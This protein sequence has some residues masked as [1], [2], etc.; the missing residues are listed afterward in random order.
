MIIRYASDLHLDFSIPEVNDVL[1]PALPDDSNSVLV[2][3]G[4]VANGFRGNDYIKRLSKRF[5][6]IIYVLGNHEYYGKDI[7]TIKRKLKKSF[8]EYK[9]VHILE[10]DFVVI[11]IDGDLA[12][13]FGCTLWT[14]FAHDFA[15]MEK[16][17]L[18]MNDYYQIRNSLNGNYRQRLTPQDSKGLHEQ[19]VEALLNHVD[20]IKEKNITSDIL[21]YKHIVV[22]HH[23]PSYAC[24]HKDFFNSDIN[25]AFASNLDELIKDSGI[26]YWIHGHT[27][28]PVDV[29][30]DKTR[31]LCNPRGY[32][33]R[34]DECNTDFNG[35]AYIEI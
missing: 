20:L 29:M 26:D 14:D 15:I 10:N 6:C 33:G 8:K 3:A 16:A 30:V 5:K 28:K 25:S 35:N 24:I 9:N 13:F 23:L 31:V 22:S 18:I 32:S 27:H 19:S 12:T 21:R 34:M 11:N 7:A 1:I 17:K 4:D 2:I